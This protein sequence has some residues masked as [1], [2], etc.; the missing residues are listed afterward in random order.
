MS[1]RE[2]DALDRIAETEEERAVR[3]ELA[4]LTDEEVKKTLAE[5]GLD[6]DE[7][8]AIMAGILARAPGGGGA[9]PRGWP[10]AA[11]GIGVA[12]A[13]VG[14]VA[15]VAWMLSQKPPPP[16]AQQEP[17]PA[18]SPSAAPSEVPFDDLVAH[19][20]PADAGPRR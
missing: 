16:P 2:K 5:H 12:A 4:A 20:P 18:A 7:A 10:R 6:E 14:V 9:P 15:V 8:R 3:E 1:N 17:P 13:V 19:P 11:V